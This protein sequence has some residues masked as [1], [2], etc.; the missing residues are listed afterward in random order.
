MHMGSEET[1]NG[2]MVDPNPSRAVDLDFPT[3]GRLVGGEAQNLFDEAEVVNDEIQ[4][5]AM[6]ID[7]EPAAR[8]LDLEAEVPSSP[9]ELIARLNGIGATAYRLARHVRTL[10]EFRTIHLVRRADAEAGR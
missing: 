6:D 5:L 3:L 9:E 2:R 10:V 8:I 7:W 1:E 4:V